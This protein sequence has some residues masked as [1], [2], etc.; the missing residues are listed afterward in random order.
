MPL[1][2]ELAC[3]PASSFR[4]AARNTPLGHRVAQ[5][6]RHGYRQ[7][8]LGRPLDLLDRVNPRARLWLFGEEGDPQFTRADGWQRA[9]HG[10]HCARLGWDGHV[11]D[12]HSLRNHRGFGR[13][14]RTHSN[15]ENNFRDDAVRQPAAG[16]CSGMRGNRLFS[17]GAPSSVVMIHI[18]KSAS[19]LLT[20]CV[21][22]A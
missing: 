9:R 7:P 15:A 14:T 1:L 6:Q 3:A 2:P 22:S 4:S 17:A 13:Q 10:G 18:E 20:S 11:D 21:C 19:R 8:R 5:D 16:T 12:G